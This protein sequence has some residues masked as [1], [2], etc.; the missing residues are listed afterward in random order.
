MTGEPRRDEGSSETGSDLLDM[1]TAIPVVG[2][3]ISLGLLPKIVIDSVVLE[4]ARSGRSPGAIVGW[5]LAIG[6]VT[7]A[8]TYALVLVGAIVPPAVLALWIGLLIVP[9][10]GGWV[11]GGR[12]PGL[13]GFALSF[14]GLAIG[15]LLGGLAEWA[16]AALGGPSVNEEGGL[17]LGVALGLG[18]LFV[19][20]MSGTQFGVGLL[21]ATVVGRRRRGS[22]QG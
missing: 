16:L 22:G 12:A 13:G 19:P 4:A 3:L 14:V 20:V 6:A 5:A 17:S 10:V 18:A 9:V 1:L 21:L 8:L 7:G 11:A 2:E 15:G